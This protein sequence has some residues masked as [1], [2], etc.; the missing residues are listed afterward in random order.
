MSVKRWMT[1]IADL[2]G[3]MPAVRPDSY[4]VLLAGDL[5][6]DGGLD[7]QREWLHGPFSRWLERLPCPCVAVPGNHDLFLETGPVALPNCRLTC[8]FEVCE[9]AGVRIATQPLVLD[10]GAFKGSEEEIEEGL[11]GVPPGIDVL[12]SHNPPLGILDSP[13]AAHHPGSLALRHFCWKQRPRLCLFGHIHEARGHVSWRDTYFV[14]CT[15]GAGCDSRGNPVP[16]PHP[17]WGLAD[18]SWRRS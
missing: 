10:G 14:N 17:P 2:H 6:P 9:V 13:S 3:R 15:L 5:C 18:D 4:L 8:M 16:A 1:C 12:L 11:A 7:R